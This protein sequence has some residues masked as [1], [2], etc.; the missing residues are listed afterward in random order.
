MDDVSIP[1]LMGRLLGCER[2]YG[3]YEPIVC[4]NTLADGQAPRIKRNFLFK[5]NAHLCLNTLA[6]G[7]A[8]RIS[9]SPNVI[10]TL[11][12]VSIPS[13][14]GR[15]LGFMV[16]SFILPKRLR[17]NTLADG[18]APRILFFGTQR[19]YGRV[20]IPSLMGRLLGCPRPASAPSRYPSSQYPR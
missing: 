18:Q 11:E 17:L 2:Y 12:W 20:S 19:V 9:G 5:F 16:A 1:S 14:M 15:L 10:Q 3:Q 6:D 13:L 8:P 4:L 7:Q